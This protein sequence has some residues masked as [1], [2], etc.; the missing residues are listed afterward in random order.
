MTVDELLD[1]LS[2]AFPAFNARALETWAPIYRSTL[3]KH[4]GPALKSAFTEVLSTFQVTKAKT[5]YPMVSDFVARLPAG[6]P[7]VPG[8]PA[9]DIKGQRSR[10][11]S[12]MSIWR[13]GQG[14]RGSKGVPEV[15]QALEFIAHPI[16][17]AAAWNENPEPVLLTG[18]QLKL[19]Q[20]RAI[21]QQRR[22]K[23][24]PP[25]RDPDLWWEQI[26]AIAHGWG[27]ATTRDEWTKDP[28]T[29]QAA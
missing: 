28:P 7:K 23:H 5:L 8:G 13:A 1:K 22:V 29:V 26:S 2:R 17:E 21:S 3:G 6:H 15:L 27:I 16:A 14:L 24:G 19:A 12:L 20:Q 9:L 18:K 11:N 25:G 10:L 4:E